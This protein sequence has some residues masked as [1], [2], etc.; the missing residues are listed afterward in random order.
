MMCLRVRL[1]GPMEITLNGAPVSDF[2]SSKARAL[3]AYLMMEEN[4]PHC[5]ETLA[6]LLWPDY[7]ESAARA[8]LR[9]GISKLRKAVGG[10]AAAPPFLDITRET[11]QFNKTGDCWCD[12]IAFGDAARADPASETAVRRWEEA[13]SLYRGSFLEGFS[14]ADSAS[15]EQ[16]A[17]LKQEQLRCRALAILDQLI[18]YYELQG[19]YERACEYA[20]RQMELEPWQEQTHRTLMR[21]LALSGRRSA[22]LAQYDTCH[23]LLKEELDVTPDEETVRLYEQIKD[24]RLAPVKENRLS[25]P[26]VSVSSLPDAC[27]GSL[28]LYPSPFIGRE[29][30]LAKIERLLADPS[31]RLLTVTG[32]GGVGKTRLALQVA[33]RIAPESGG[34]SSSGVFFVSLASLESADYLVPTIANALNLSL[35]PDRDPQ[36]Q[37]LDYLRNKTL[38]LVLDN[39]EHLLEGTDLLADILGGSPGVRLLVTSRERLNLKWESPIE[40]CGL[41]VPGHANAGDVE[42]H[43]AVQLFLQSARR[44]NPEF[45]LSEST[46]PRVARICRHLEGIPLAIELAAA[47]VETLPC[48]EIEREIKRSLNLLASPLRD[49]PDRHRSL[50]AAFDHSWNLLSA[51]EQGLF[52]RLSVFR[53]SFGKEAAAAVAGASLQHLVALAYKS[54]LQRDTPGRYRMLQVLRQYAEDRFGGTQ[55][56]IMA[57][58]RH[59]EYYAHF[60]QQ[61]EE[62]IR[63][64]NQCGVLQ[65]ITRV[66]D[67]VRAGWQWAIAHCKK[68]ALACEMEG[69]FRYYEA[70][71]K[72][73]EGAGAF[74]KAADAL[75]KVVDKAAKSQEESLELAEFR[76][77]L[78]GV[79]ARQGG[80]YSWTVYR[81][82]TR[83][84]LQESLDILR[85]LGVHRDVAR[86]LY[87]MSA[88][89]VYSGDFV[90]AR[91]LCGEALAMFKELGNRSDIAQCL[92]GLGNIT[93]W[94]GELAEGKQYHQEA[95]A[96]WRSLGDLR[97]MSSALLSLG[98]V[99]QGLGEYTEAEGLFQQVLLIC[100]EVG[101]R[102]GLRN[103]YFSLGFLAR[104]LKRYD[105]AGQLYRQAFSICQRMN[106]EGGMAESYFCQ[107]NLARVVEKYDEARKLYQQAFRIFQRIGD[108]TRIEGCYYWLGCLAQE[109]GEYDKAKQL[110]QQALSISQTMHFETEIANCYFVQGCLA[111]TL[112]NYD[113]AK[114]LYLK[115]LALYRKIG[116]WQGEV[117]SLCFLGSIFCALGKY[118]VANEYVC[119]ILKIVSDSVARTM[120]KVYGLVGLGVIL[121]QKEEQSARAVEIATFTLDHP[122]IVFD[123]KKRAQRLLSELKPKLPGDVFAAAQ[124]RGKAGDLETYMGF[125]ASHC[126]GSGAPCAYAAGGR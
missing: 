104:E 86:D 69:L 25:K 113:E 55:E 80:L 90:T 89:V 54:L 111:E 106:D 50:Q 107:G 110:Y 34:A 53:G 65:E 77:L 51:K 15:F 43:S 108:E 78:G 42:A 10:H 49:V 48:R 19:D 32:P 118:E 67:D 8:N 20:R 59:C 12:A 33:G 82:E 1:L 47:W 112:G 79:L 100:H 28:P 26:R 13:V 88:M 60:L 61:R 29:N 4:R 97:G 99:A 16:W 114:E 93:R 22:A 96:I 87:A 84:I 117:W 63:G 57:C 85:P 36:K 119:A 62:N 125:W 76:T 44:V 123:A 58:D 98:E 52:A 68:E 45:R 39:F 102:M 92:N 24:G 120:G 2:T 66:I 74:G 7:P 30:E 95:L 11:I 40:I 121:A 73:E 103:C 9:N 14:I 38:L 64:R 31:R 72:V 56:W 75:R 18:T 115:A 3:L 37:L 35:Y 27:T 81:E 109:L 21:L 116:Y 6:G 46:G 5:R 41:D 101:D 122:K 105:E 124:E 91:C 94:W 23:C 17:L 83:G 70:Q 71:G 126:E